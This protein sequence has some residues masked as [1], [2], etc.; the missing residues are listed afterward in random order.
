MFKNLSN[1]LILQKRIPNVFLNVEYSAEGIFGNCCSIF[2]KTLMKLVHR[3]FYETT[4]DNQNRNAMIFLLKFSVR[5]NTIQST[6]PQT[7]QKT[8]YPIILV[9]V[10]SRRLVNISL[11][12]LVQRFF[13]V[14]K[15][16]PNTPSPL[17]STLTRAF[18][19]H[20]D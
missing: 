19:L 8:F 10:I 7:T 17:Y 11:C 5:L 2:E 1:L 15:Q 16:I 14:T 3:S 12:K 18:G 9:V 4:R 6:S 20:F 13:S